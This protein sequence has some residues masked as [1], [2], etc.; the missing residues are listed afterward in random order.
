MQSLGI[1]RG[2]QDFYVRTTLNPATRLGGRTLK[3]FYVY[4]T[5]EQRQRLEDARTLQLQAQ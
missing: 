4:A 2:L 5:P 1:P 3:D